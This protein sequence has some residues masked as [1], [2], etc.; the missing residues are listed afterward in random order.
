MAALP[1]TAGYVS[2]GLLAPIE[3]INIKKSKKTRKKKHKKRYKIPHSSYSSFFSATPPVIEISLPREIIVTS[4]QP[5]LIRHAIFPL[6]DGSHL[7]PIFLSLLIVRPA[8][9]VPSGLGE[10]AFTPSSP[11]WLR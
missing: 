6:S 9:L 11:G 1:N 3:T 5:P 2:F 10:S 8:E 7:P 4:I